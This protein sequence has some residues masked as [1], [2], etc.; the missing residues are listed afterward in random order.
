MEIEG[1]LILDL[2]LEEGVSQR[3]GNS[4]KKKSW[5]LETMGQYPRKA[6]FD[7]FGDRVEMFKQLEVGKAYSVSV[8]VESREFNG[9]WYTDL[10]AFNFRPLENVQPG[11]PQPMPQAQQFGQPAPQAYAPQAPAGPQFSQ[12]AAPAA[13]AQQPLPPADATEDLP[14]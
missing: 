11:Y 13:P 6:K 7:V 2:P 5:V 4:W 10:R 8:D 12:P 14:F 1:I 9:R 3:T